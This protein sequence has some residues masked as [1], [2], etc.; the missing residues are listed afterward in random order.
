[1]FRPKL[2]VF[3]I[4]IFSVI[5][6]GVSHA[7]SPDNAFTE[8]L[9]GG[10]IDVS[11]RLRRETVKQDNV[12]E[13]AAANTLRSRLT[14][15]TG[16]LAGFSGLVEF[17]N[18]VAL[19]S[20]RYD[21]FITDRYRGNYS[22]IADPVGSEVNQALIGYNFNEQQQVILGRQRILHSGQRFVGGVG[23]RQ[24]EQTYDAVGY[25]FRSPQLDADYS[26]VWNV[27]RIFGGSGNSAQ[28]RDLDGNSHLSTLTLKYPWG[29][30][31]AFAYILEF[32]EAAALSTTTFGMSYSGS[33]GPITLQSSVARQSD[34][35]R[36]PQSYDASYLSLEAGFKID[37]VNL[38][39]GYELLGSDGGRSAFITP[40]ATLHIF[41]GWADMFLATPADGIEDRYATVSGEIGALRLS[42]TYHDF[43]ADEGGADYGGEWDLIAGYPINS[44]FSLEFKYAT[45]D[46]DGYKVDTEKL[47]FSLIVAF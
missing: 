46:E 6:V 26:Y 35:G 44:N 30:V 15:R 19:G 8:F 29:D 24:N 25:R 33:L 42:A 23:W 16:N 21:S 17:D 31:G 4:I 18:V 34:R 10:N 28:L 36:N 39:A 20:D 45:Y 7:Q 9:S 2:Y 38:L 32:D 40:L 14:L 41:Q 47:W 43:Q 1:M 13:D 5:S 11:M 22:V 12:L 37:K 27:N 3:F